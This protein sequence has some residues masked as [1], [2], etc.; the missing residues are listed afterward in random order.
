MSEAAK[1]VW[2][3]LKVGYEYQLGFWGHLYGR[4]M[5]NVKFGV[6][7]TFKNHTHQI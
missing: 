2:F 6:A 1:I 3:S 4:H 7:Y 5:H